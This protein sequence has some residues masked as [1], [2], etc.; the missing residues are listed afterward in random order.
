MSDHYTVLL[1]SL[2]SNFFDVFVSFVTQPALKMTWNGIYNALNFHN[3]MHLHV[4][5]NIL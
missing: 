5:Q 4:K 1:Q 3:G 2:S